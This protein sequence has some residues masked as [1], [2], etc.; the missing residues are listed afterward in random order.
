MFANLEALP[1]D[2]ILG[3]TKIFAEDP[4]QNKIDLGVGVYKTI[5]GVTPVMKAVAEAQNTII[6]KEATKS[7]TP[8]QGAPG[9]GEAM[10][11]LLFGDSDV[12]G[13]GRCTAVQTPG[14][15]GAL[16]LAGELLNHTGAASITIGTPTWPN[17]K[18][19]LSAAGLTINMVPYYEAENSAIAF[20]S[21]VSAV[22]KLG[23]K[24]ALLL[25]GPCHNPTGA[26][27]T[28]EQI[29]IIIDVAQERGFLPLIDTA[30]HGF[31]HD[32]ETDAYIIRAMSERLP[33]VLITYSCSKNFG[34]YKERTGGIIYVGENAERASAVKTHIMNIARSNYSMPPAHGG[35]IVSEILHSPEL[36]KLWRD[37]LAEMTATVR[38]NRKLLVET[39]A[40]A[41]HGNYFAHIGQQNGMFSLLPMSDAQ[42]AALREDHGVYAVGG[43]R[44]NMCGVNEHN[45]QHL[46]DAVNSV[47]NG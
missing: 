9:F 12:L 23:P 38:S 25:H 44:I 5:D 10:L 1:A 43:G 33:E 13:R 16:R 4:R 17:H 36:T 41:G 22:K 6:S 20:D 46:V 45:V 7:Y 34:L 19:L 11:K 32:L 18:P 24:D 15:C 29:D 26:D 37:E 31:A 42:V 47:V 35:A 27:L 8:P 30:Y 40:K 21:F 3:I 28:P 14:G 39:A 2:P